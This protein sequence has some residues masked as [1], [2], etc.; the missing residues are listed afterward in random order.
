MIAMRMVKPALDQIIDVIAVRNCFMPAAWPMRVLRLVAIVPKFRRAA[1]CIPAVDLVH[2]LFDDI[3][4]LTV[5]M[6]V[7]EVI[8]AIAVLDSDVPAGG[9][10]P[11][12]M[13][14]VNGVAIVC[15]G[16]SFL[17]I[18][19]LDQWGSQACAIALST[20]LRTWASAI[21]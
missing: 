18:V 5:Q 7:M 12:G 16:S 17:S 10:V 4:F 1:V 21:E 14:G 15:H 13:V 9:T 6:A 20:R 2:L 11:M 19:I 8:D 3:A